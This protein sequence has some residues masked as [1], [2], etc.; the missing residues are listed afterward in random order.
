MVL[1]IGKFHCTERDDA[2]N[3]HVFSTSSELARL[4]ALMG[5]D[6]C[7]GRNSGAESGGRAIDRANE[8]PP[9]ASPLAHQDS[10]AEKTEAYQHGRKMKAAGPS[11]DEPAAA[12]EAM[13]S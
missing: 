1:R 6:L 12:G 3:V 8:A 9:L 5:A 2:C 10:F 11:V 4:R 7:T 13:P